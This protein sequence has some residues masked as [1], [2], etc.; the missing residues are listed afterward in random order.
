MELNKQNRKNGK[1]VRRQGNK[2]N[3]RIVENTGNIIDYRRCDRKDFEI[4]K[5]R[6]Q[7][8]RRKAQDCEKK[9]SERK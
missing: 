4:D 6:R 7:Q 2:N 9:R 8:K 3:V 5:K 1:K